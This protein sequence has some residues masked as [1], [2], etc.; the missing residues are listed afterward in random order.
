MTDP[1]EQR[2]LQDYPVHIPAL[3][4]WSDNDMYGHL[5]NAVYYEV[6]D[7]AI[8][9]WLAENV[10]LNYTETDV[11]GV[12][13]ESGCRFHGELAFPQALTVGLRVARLGRSSVV[14]D[15]ALFE[16]AS[17]DLDASARATCRWVHVYLDR[18]SKRSTEIPTGLHQLMEHA[19]GATNELQNA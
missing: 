15:L 5:N 12:V 1:L 3:T 4:R 7:S 17:P 18:S 9:G 8:N 19:L 10:A 16:G 13:A 2:T 6:F 14:Y 11:I